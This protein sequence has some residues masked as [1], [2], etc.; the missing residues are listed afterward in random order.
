MVAKMSGSMCEKIVSIFLTPPTGN[1][2]GNR[3][4]KRGAKVRDG[5][6][7]NKLCFFLFLLIFVLA[8]IRPSASGLPSSVIGCHRL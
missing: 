7:D 4:C 6:I 8:F 2:F 5:G 1:V 3:K